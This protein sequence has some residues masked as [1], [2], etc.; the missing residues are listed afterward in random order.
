MIYDDHVAIIKLCNTFKDKLSASSIHEIALELLQLESEAHD[1]LTQHFQLEENLLFPAIIMNDPS[2]ETSEKIILLSNQHG[3]ISQMF[4]SLYRLTKT[5][6]SKD[7]QSTQCEN[8]FVTCLDDL[9]SL[10]VD[11]ETIES[12][13]FQQ[14]EV[15]Q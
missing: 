8:I 7:S 6:L 1:L 15:N 2:V 3:K 13:F 4:L 10:I 9:I 14:H 12:L 5:I 11:H